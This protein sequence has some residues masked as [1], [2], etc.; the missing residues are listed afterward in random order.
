[1]KI[2]LYLNTESEK[3]DVQFN[4]QTLTSR[5]GENKLEEN[6]IVLFYSTMT[7]FDLERM[8]SLINGLSQLCNDVLYGFW[9]AIAG[10]VFFP[11]E[12]H[13]RTFRIRI[14]DRL[15]FIRVLTKVTFT[16]GYYSSIECNYPPSTRKFDE[17]YKKLVTFPPALYDLSHNINLQCHFVLAAE[18]SFF[19]CSIMFPFLIEQENSINTDNNH[20]DQSS[21]S[22]P[23]FSSHQLTIND[24][25]SSYSFI[26][27]KKHYCSRPFRN[28]KRVDENR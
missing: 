24:F 27:L 14:D 26:Y 13:W 21:I 18:R 8:K 23:V 9:H 6:I 28:T 17:Y 2:V 16:D 1:M 19:M 25:F 20:T 4:L 5:T 12:C 22:F 3:I 10:I 11:C 7:E 15:V